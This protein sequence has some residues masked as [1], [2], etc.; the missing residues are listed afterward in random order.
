MHSEFANRGNLIITKYT[1]F[2]NY[3]F[4]TLIIFD[5]QPHQYDNPLEKKTLL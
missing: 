2:G 3:G 5:D 4:K 1:L